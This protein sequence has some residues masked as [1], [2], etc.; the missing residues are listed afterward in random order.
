MKWIVATAMVLVFT[1][2]VYK[3]ESKGPDGV[4]DSTQWAVWKCLDEKER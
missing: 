1:G 3:S 4:Y 2:C